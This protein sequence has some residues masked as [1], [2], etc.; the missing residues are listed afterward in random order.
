MLVAVDD[1][2]VAAA[3][4]E[5]DAS[6]VELR[7]E[8]HRWPERSG[9]ER[10]TAELVAER[11][12]AA[13]LAVATGIGGHGVVA[14][15]N[16]AGDGPTVAYRADMDALDLPDALDRPEALDLPE[17]FVSGFASRGPGVAH[18]CG[19]D[20]HTAIGVGIAQVLARLR[21]RLPGRV[22]FFF[23]PAEE[24]L[25]GARAMIEADALEQVAPREIYALHCGPLPVGR[26]AVMPGFGLPG[27]DRFRITLA[28]PT[29]AADADRLA[30]RIEALTTVQLTR[31]R[32]QTQRLLA[33]LER[34]GGP[35]AR[36]VV[37]AATV[38]SDRRGARIAGWVR[39]WP[40]ERYPEIR[41]R[42]RYLADSVGARIAFPDPPFPAMVCSPELS[43]ALA[44]H[45][46]DTLGPDAVTVLHGSYPTHSEDFARFLREVPGAMCY[47]GVADAAA[48]IHG[49]PHSP[50]FAADERAVGVGVRAMAG[51]LASRLAAPP[52]DPSTGR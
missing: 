47:L 48:G 13:G 16:G 27:Q 24:T 2:A 22:G 36:F 37:I 29:A 8:I 44:A 18:L 38:E 33:S 50:D 6:L 11:L 46:R 12:E 42:L 41:V 14:V 32:E 31:D 51:F 10:R 43:Q 5:L 34:P 28:G 40:D 52:A 21:D 3:A 49:V 39:A 9:E 15:L 20:L 23:Q 19:H 45:L 17:A 1:A 35:L 26:F 7:R 25:T 4:A 30:G